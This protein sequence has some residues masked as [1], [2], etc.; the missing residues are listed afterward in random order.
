MIIEFVNSVIGIQEISEKFLT[1]YN[2]IR[3]SAV[4]IDR[5][6]IKVSSDVEIIDEL[7]YSYISLFSIE[8]SQID[9][10]LIF[11]NVRPN[12]FFIAKNK[13]QLIK[14]CKITSPNKTNI[15]RVIEEKSIT[16]IIVVNNNTIQNLFSQNHFFEETN[17][18]IKNNKKV[19]SKYVSRK[20]D[21]FNF[22][23]SLKQESLLWQY[24]LA[25]LD[26]LSVL[27][28]FYY[29]ENRI[30]FRV[31]DYDI[32]LSEFYVRNVFESLQKN[33][34][35]ELSE[36]QIY[37][38]R[39]FTDKIKAKKD[40]CDSFEKIKNF[41]EKLLYYLKYVKS[42]T[43][44]IQELAQ[45]IVEHSGD[46]KDKGFGVISA[47]VFTKEKFKNIK[48][49]SNDFDEWLQ[50]AIDDEYFLDLNIID[51]GKIDIRT[52]YIEKLISYNDQSFDDDLN[53]LNNQTISILF[54]YQ[55]IQLVHQVKREMA[56]LGLLIFSNEV[57]SRNGYIQATSNG[58]KSKVCESVS[59]FLKNN[60]IC[61][62]EVQNLKNPIG[63]SYNFII[64]I[65]KFK[66]VNS[67]S[68]VV[69]AVT[70]YYTVES[71]KELYD[72]HY[73]S[74]DIKNKNKKYFK[75]VTIDSLTN[76]NKYEKIN[77]LSESIIKNR[78]KDEILIL[79]TKDDFFNS[80]LSS[81]SDWL[82]F[83][84][85]IQ[86]NNPLP[87]IFL[88]DDDFFEKTYLEIIKINKFFSEE[89]SL[90]FWNNKANLIFYFKISYTEDEKNVSIWFNNVLTGNDYKDYVNINKDISNYHFN[91]LA[92]L[93]DIDESDNHIYDK[94]G[95]NEFFKNGKLLSLELIIK[96]SNNK[97][98]FLDT[99]ESLLNLEITPWKSES[100]DKKSTYFKQLSG[101][102]ISDAHFKLGSKIHIKDFYYAKPMFYNS[103]FANRFAFILS[104]YIVENQL[105]T[106][107]PDKEVTIIGYENYSELLVSQIRN[108]INE[109]E[110]KNRIK[111]DII[112]N[113]SVLKSTSNISGYIILIVPISSTFSTQQKV[114][115]IL[116]KINSNEKERN[117]K[118]IDSSTK[119][120][121]HCD[122][123]P[124]YPDLSVLL[125]AD[126]KIEE[127]FYNLTGEANNE[128]E[129]DPNK[130]TIYEVF[131]WKKE[132]DN[133]IKANGRLQHYF[134]NVFTDWHLNYRCKLCFTEEIKKEKCILD[135]EVNSVTPD[136]VFDLPKISKPNDDLNV[137]ELLFNKPSTKNSKN[138][139]NLIDES[140]YFNVITRPLKRRSHNY[141][142]YIKTSSFLHKSDSNNEKIKIW[143]N[144]LRTKYFSEN[145]KI[146]LLKQSEISISGFVDMVN[147]I[148]FD[149]TATILQFSPKDDNVQNFIKFHKELL[150]DAEII[151]IDDVLAYGKYFALINNYIKNLDSNNSKIN[152]FITFCN[153]MNYYDEKILR[154]DLGKDG[155]LL[156][157]CKINIPSLLNSA[158]Q[159]FFSKKIEIYDKLMTKSLLDR[160]RVY[161]KEKKER[162]VSK[163]LDIDGEEPNSNPFGLFKALLYHEVFSCFSFEKEEYLNNQLT[164]VFFKNYGLVAVT[165]LITLVKNSQ[166]VKSFIKQFPFF[167]KEIDLNIIRIISEPPFSRYKYLK[168]AAFEW[169][170]GKL[171][172]VNFDNPNYFSYENEKDLF[173]QYQRDKLL[174]AIAINLNVNYLISTNFLWKIK[175]LITK[176]NSLDSSEFKRRKLQF[177]SKSWNIVEDSEKVVFNYQGF[178]TY[179]SGLVQ[180]LIYE[181]D[182]KAAELVQNISY[183]INEKKV[184]D[185]NGN[186]LRLTNDFKNPYIYLM[187]I[188]VLENNFIF[189][190]FFENFYKEN[191]N[192]IISIGLTSSSETKAK[193]KQF[194]RNYR[195]EA[196]EIMLGN[197][198][199]NFERNSNLEN[200]FY[201]TID[202]K[203]RLKNEKE[204][205]FEIDNTDSDK[206]KYPIKVKV[207][208]LLERLCKVLNIKDGGAYLT[209]R[210]E[211]KNVE[212]SQIKISDLYTINQYATSDKYALDN[213]L[214]IEDCIMHRVFKGIKDRGSKKPKSTFELYKDESGVWSNR[215]VVDII[216]S[217]EEIQFNS[218]SFLE[219][220]YEFKNKEVKYKNLFFL[221]ISD[222]NKK[223]TERKT[224][225]NKLFQTEP[226]AV[227]TFYAETIDRN[228]DSEALYFSQKNIRFLLLL[229]DY[230]KDFING[231]SD[232]DSLAGFIAEEKKNEIKNLFKHGIDVYQNSINL[233][234]ALI[235]N[236]IP[237]G[238]IKTISN[239]YI[240]KLNLITTLNNNIVLIDY[241]IDDLVKRFNDQ[242]INV[243]MFL[244]SRNDSL[245]SKDLVDYKEIT[246]EED[247][248][249]VISIPANFIDELVFEL[250]YNI[251]KHAIAKS[252]VNSNK[253]LEVSLEIKDQSDFYNIKL[254]NNHSLLISYSTVLKEKNQPDGLNLINKILMKMNSKNEIVVTNDSGIFSLNLKLHK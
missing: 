102:K 114:F 235:D 221:R 228:P 87:L 92:L 99:V 17:L 103:F 23:K 122:I 201:E 98:L 78:E 145:K 88:G 173:C 43:I 86:L 81:P 74:D 246:K 37:L 229:R 113:E 79:D 110:G 166:S 249:K 194:Y 231:Q 214:E 144:G 204:N 174:F 26:D 164:Q 219:T 140:E 233:N 196:L 64:P 39:I 143:L 42:I 52:S 14:N 189:E 53:V 76:H 12:L 237:K 153:K 222:I 158:E 170:I 95:D 94:I 150:K 175:N 21:F 211:N 188:L 36:I 80:T 101:Y 109:Y 184:K 232:N 85:V 72:Y 104:R 128:N 107:P 83:L 225:A 242:Y 155:E 191:L 134:I 9:I 223:Q 167:S 65:S 133:T 40:E 179:Y 48:Y 121:P 11:D 97:I 192:S 180:E 66:D 135:T 84:A 6:V 71:T 10:E 118:R 198:K 234:L 18:I 35:F 146:V 130:R 160:S 13:V 1:N 138:K 139:K 218:S 183:I 63:T 226:I 195:S 148:I 168:E 15:G 47:R 8:F 59:L 239:Y 82:R 44:G 159:E 49:S 54:D 215:P 60:K 123:E 247:R 20:D 30:E 220:D 209:I 69:N 50:T 147:K 3:S 172:G 19:F 205:K 224:E 116:K 162:L 252:F 213:K 163:D 46:K 197:I 202:L 91:S 127:E 61:S 203:I 117:G 124:L 75:S 238:Y 181:D 70:P 58:L 68:Y 25:I 24:Y 206:D 16:P 248:E 51:S 105:K 185:E 77:I 2:L 178:I 217:T 41:I 100:S 132:E 120:L 157:F 177:N 115:N 7:L 136:L 89:S 186:L 62:N 152:H 240:N 193:I 27:R 251:R 90:N 253:K 111:H 141:R 29:G 22:F 216:D 108:K 199:N 5:L 156:A 208:K 244:H 106:I 28:I 230:I 169:V 34:F 236:E 142:F 149:D 93:D 31:D 250:L 126:N 129:I 55:N 32:T 165:D 112:V 67:K 245:T 161:F 56:R 182:A 190:K 176:L 212:S 137:F 57:L 45:N 119:L 254:Q 73:L 154:K 131:N 171:K 33:G 210:Y 187:K 200:A 241:S 38:F 227:I 4:K 243:F 207:Y 96:S 151:Y 125:V